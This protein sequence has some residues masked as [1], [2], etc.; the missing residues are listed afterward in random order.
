MGRITGDQ[1]LSEDEQKMLMGEDP[2]A[3]TDD[4]EITVEDEPDDDEEV[5][6]KDTEEESEEEDEDKEPEEKPAKDPSER[7]V[8]HGAFHQERERRKA[9]EKSFQEV[10]TKYEVLAARFNDMLAQIR[11]DGDGGG[12]QAATAEDDP[13]PDRVAEPFKYME[14]LERQN[15]KLRDDVQGVKKTVEDGQKQTR[16]QQEFAKVV[17]HGNR[18]A[19]EFAS[20]TPDYNDAYNFAY[21]KRAEQLEMAGFN[22]DQ[23]P[24]MIEQE[25]IAGML[26]CLRN[27]INPGEYLYK[28][29]IS[30]GYKPGTTPESQKLEK[31][32]EGQK[33]F[34]SLG[35]GGERKTI[36]ANSAEDIVRM[37]DSEFKAW[38]KKNP[39]GLAK[40]FG[41]G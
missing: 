14:W 31:V 24:G 5:E 10:N 21:N 11:G 19:S 17:D 16:Q 8:P 27:K 37:S 20:K 7:K 12:D 34:K 33:K 13:A 41:Q 6:E 15:A 29:A 39:R 2:E 26:T 9:V 18:L 40:I 3:D 25:K 32:K 23:I 35:S 30:Q 22:A 28:F 38:K 4:N 1:S 36:V